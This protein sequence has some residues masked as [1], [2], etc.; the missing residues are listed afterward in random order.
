MGREVRK[1]RDHGLG[2]VLVGIVDWEWLVEL[3]ALA[4]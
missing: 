1:V 2:E 3:D 4:E